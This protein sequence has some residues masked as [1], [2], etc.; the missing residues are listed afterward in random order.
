MQTDSIVSIA[1][2]LAAAQQLMAFE[3][4]AEAERESVGRY[5]SNRKPLVQQE[6]S[7]VHH[8]E[9]LITLRATSEHS[10][11]D[12]IVESILKICHCEL[13]DFLFRSKVDSHF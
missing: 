5:L 11:L 13:I 6:A 1:N 9:D 2:T 4:P 8:K 12:S 3:K 10:W 7:W